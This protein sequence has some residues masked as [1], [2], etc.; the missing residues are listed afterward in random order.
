MNEIKH[1]VTVWLMGNF[2][3]IF[4]AELELSCL[5]EWVGIGRGGG[6]MV[7]HP[8]S[9]RPESCSSATRPDLHEL[10]VSGHAKIRTCSYRLRIEELS[11][12][13]EYQTEA[14]DIF[15]A[16]CSW[17]ILYR[18]TRKSTCSSCADLGGGGP[19]PPGICKLNIADITRNEK[20]IVFFHICALLQLYVKQNQS[21][22]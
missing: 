11:F 7:P 20:K 22:K 16:P 3:V 1:D 21:T 2:V 10:Y 18:I 8:S 4:P 15:G 14:E 5:K 12:F 19:D 6:S 13:V 9:L 17:G